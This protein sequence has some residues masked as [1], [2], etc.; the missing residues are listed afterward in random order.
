M[1]VGEAGRRRASA[2]DG[3]TRLFVEPRQVGFLMIPG[4]SGRVGSELFEDCAA[5]RGS[6]ETELVQILDRQA[7]FRVRQSQQKVF[8]GDPHGGGRAYL[9]CANDSVLRTTLGG[10]R[11]SGGRLCVIQFASSWRS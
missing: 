7:L 11:R 9:R 10:K 3:G 8:L 5:Q 1:E 2:A 6:V 4:G